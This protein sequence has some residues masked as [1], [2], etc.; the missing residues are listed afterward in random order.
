MQF[1]YLPTDNLS[2]ESQEMEISSEK[3]IMEIRKEQHNRTKTRQKED[4]TDRKDTIETNNKNQS[5]NIIT[6]KT[7][8]TDY[9]KDEWTRVQKRAQ[10]EKWNK[11][12]VEETQK[13]KKENNYTVNK[14]NGEGKEIQLKGLAHPS[15]YDVL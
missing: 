2:R 9:I 1:F 13:Q 15:Y 7:K 11:E 10:V 12:N 8:K 5:P 3:D 14:R 6:N 4:F